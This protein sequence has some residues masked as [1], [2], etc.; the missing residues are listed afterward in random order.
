IV[1]P[2]KSRKKSL[3]FSRTR[4]STPARASRNPS[5]MPAGP[6]PAMQHVVLS[7]IE[8]FG[9]YL[10]VLRQS[11][12]SKLTVPWDFSSGPESSSK[13]GHP[14]P[15]FASKIKHQNHLGVQPC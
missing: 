4:T 11:L 10:N 12:G 3:C 14:N 15:D 2:R 1:S 6:P 7:F 9:C 5:M 13:V 8:S